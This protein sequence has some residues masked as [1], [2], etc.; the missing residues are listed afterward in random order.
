MKSE[1]DC[2][3]TRESGCARLESGTA[4]MPGVSEKR[5]EKAARREKDKC[6]KFR[7]LACLGRKKGH[8]IR[9]ISKD[10]KTAYS[11]IRDWLLRMRDRGLKGR[12]NARPKGRRAKLPLQII[13]TVRRRLKRSPKKRGFETGSWQMD[14]VIEMI[15]KEF[16]VT[17]RARTL[18]R[19]LR[20]IGFSWRKD[21]YV[22]YRSVSKERQ[23]EFKREVGERASQRRADGMAVFAEDE[24]AIPE[25]RLRV[26]A[27]RGAR[28]GQD[29][30]LKGVCQDI[31]RDV[32]RRAANKD[33]GVD[34]L[35]DVPGIPGG[36]PHG[37]SAVIHGP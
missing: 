24:A 10:L 32:P 36:D 27:D 31:R 7:L 25:P 19:W 20:R 23:E 4:F 1:S 8:S 6:A 14:M 30:L 22:P 3:N 13:R 16:G 5:L 34:E 21:R 37:P 15:R 33:R 26:E 18:R 2:G 9:R 17:V 11:T 35:G 28:A 29:K 12:F